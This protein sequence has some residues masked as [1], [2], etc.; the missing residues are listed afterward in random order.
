MA[1]T[2]TDCRPSRTG[3][4]PALCTVLHLVSHTRPPNCEQGQSSSH[5]VHSTWVVLSIRGP[6]C[7]FC[8]TC[9]RHLGTYKLAG[10]PSPNT[11]WRN[12]LLVLRVD[13]L[14]GRRM[15]IAPNW[16]AACAPARQHQS[17]CTCRSRG[18]SQWLSRFVRIVRNRKGMAYLPLWFS[19]QFSTT[20]VRHGDHR[21]TTFTLELQGLCPSVARQ[22][23]ADLAWYLDMRKQKSD[24]Y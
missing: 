3:R 4:R 6:S 2:W 5:S 10:R 14:F 12:R 19:S 8:G 11:A 1:R 13:S 9:H 7:A 20:P 15:G 24:G 21:A 18:A 16:C 22:P 17:F 23:F